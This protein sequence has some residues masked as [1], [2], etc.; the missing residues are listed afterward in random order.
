MNRL[1]LARFKHPPCKL[2]ELRTLRKEWREALQGS[3]TADRFFSLNEE[4]YDK[5]AA[6]GG[7]VP[8]NLRIDGMSLARGQFQQSAEDLPAAGLLRLLLKLDLEKCVV[9]V[10][11]CRVL[12][13]VSDWY[14]LCQSI[15]V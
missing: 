3:D 6:A 13:A 5:L 14:Q 8:E 1:I 15:L 9:V 4:K 12:L 10:I 2:T 7:A 11:S